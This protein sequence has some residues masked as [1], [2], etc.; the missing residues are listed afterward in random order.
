[1]SEVRSAASRFERLLS[2]GALFLGIAFSFLACCAA[3][4]WSSRHNSFHH[5]QRFHQLIAQES[6]Y[7]PTASQVRALGRS[8]LDPNKIVVVVGGTSVLHGT[9]QSPDGLWTRKLQA[10]LGEEYQVI[11][12]ALRAGRTMEFGAVAAEFLAR[13]FPRLIFVGDLH[14]LALHAEPDGL[15]FKHFYWDAYYKGLLLPNPE[16]NARLDE[17]ARAEREDTGGPAAP[18]RSPAGWSQLPRHALQTEMRLDSVLYFN[19]LW[20]HLAYTRFATIW[21]PMTLGSFSRPRRRYADPDSGSPTPGKRYSDDT[22]DYRADVARQLRG[23]G[24]ACTLDSDQRW[25]ENDSAQAWTNFD[26]AARTTVPPVLRQ[27]M[28]LLVV[29]FSP[30]YLDLLSREERERFSAVSR[31]TVRHLQRFGYSAQ[32]VGPGLEADDFG[33][34]QHLVES[35]GAK[36]ADTVAPRIRALAEQLGY[37]N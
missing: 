20:N 34:L 33:D 14:P 22:D 6:Q 24:E 23:V 7:Y 30:H 25:V 27:R 3:G 11:N 28:L 32:E 8:T 18:S 9:C 12:L 26:T 36:L 5:F 2:P 21:T 37:T 10:Q 17:L 15:M 31:L 13:D 16:R 29:W 4:Y 35:G 19:D 1:M